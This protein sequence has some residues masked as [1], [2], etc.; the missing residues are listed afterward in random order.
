MSSYY[1]YRFINNLNKVIYVGR[2]NS[3]VS[4]ISTHLTKGHLP[5]ECYDSIKRIDYLECSTKNDMKIKELYYIGKFRPIYNSQDNHGITMSVDEIADCWT[6]FKVGKPQLKMLEKI[7]E[8]ENVNL[9]LSKQLKDTEARL[10]TSLN[11]TRIKEMELSKLKV[12]SIN[13]SGSQFF[14]VGDDFSLKKAIETIEG[15]PEVKFANFVDGKIQRLIY[16]LN[17]RV[18]LWSPKLSSGDIYVTGNE[19]WTYER[20]DGEGFGGVMDAGILICDN[21]IE[22]TETPNELITV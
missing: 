20:V 12:E 22:L 15:N 4:R 8:M 5:K 19:G 6:G 14:G 2:T 21:W 1:V 13:I 16:N 9:E 7:S 11:E 18:A 3:I 10:K 17:G